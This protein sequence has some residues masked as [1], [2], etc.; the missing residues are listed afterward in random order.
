MI[1]FPLDHGVWGERADQAF[2][3]VLAHQ[4]TSGSNGGLEVWVAGTLSPLVRLRRI[5]LQE[6]VDARIAF[7]D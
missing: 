1:P 6:N 3:A 2:R 5:E 7:M 4:R